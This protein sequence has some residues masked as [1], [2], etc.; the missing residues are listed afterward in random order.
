MGGSSS[1]KV[2]GPTKHGGCPDGVPAKP[3][4]KR[5]GLKKRRATQGPMF[6][7]FLVHLET[8]QGYGFV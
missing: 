3:N 5:G 2:P 1:F 4:Q 7:L 6:D 8:I